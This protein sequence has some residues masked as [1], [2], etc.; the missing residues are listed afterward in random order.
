MLMELDSGCLW[1]HDIFAIFIE[2]VHF[3]LV[4]WQ[5]YILVD[6]ES[7]DGMIACFVLYVSM[8]MGGFQLEQR[9]EELNESMS[10]LRYVQLVEEYIYHDIA[11]IIL[12]YTLQ[13]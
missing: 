3:G 2:V 5:I 4:I 12:A 13:Y 1:S 10:N 8:R 9:E 11:S 7:F 6:S